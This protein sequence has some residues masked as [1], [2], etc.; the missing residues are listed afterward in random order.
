MSQGS[1]LNFHRGDTRLGK[2]IA[3]LYSFDTLQLSSSSFSLAPRIITAQRCKV[4]VHDADNGVMAAVPVLEFSGLGLAMQHSDP[5]AQAQ[6]LP[7]PRCRDAPIAMDSALR[8]RCSNS[9]PV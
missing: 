8:L 7:P 6:E 9:P 4:L 3:S 5:R 1:Y 2:D